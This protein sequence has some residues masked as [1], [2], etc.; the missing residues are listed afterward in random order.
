MASGGRNQPHVGNQARV[1]PPSPLNTKK[2]ASE[3]K[4]FKQM[5]ENFVIVA[6]L[7]NET[8][9]YMKALFLH[10]LG[11]DGLAIVNGLELQPNHT[12][13]DIITALDSHFIGQVNETY[14]RFVFNSR[15]QREGESFEDW[16]NC[17]RRL[18]KTCNYTPNISDSLLRDRLVHGLRNKKCVEELIQDNQLTLQSCIDKCRA[19]ESSLEQ[20]KSMNNTETE[21]HAVQYKKKKEH[22]DKHKD[23]SKKKDI[24]C[25]FC[26]RF[27]EMIKEKCPAYGEECTYCRGRNHFRDVC[28]KK[29]KDEKAKAHMVGQETDSDSDEYVFSVGHDS[30]IIK[31]EMIIDNK[32]VVCQIDSGASVNVISKKHVGKRNLKENKTSLHVYNGAA[33]QTLGTV[34]LDVHNPKTKQTYKTEF[35][36]VKQDLTTL[37]GKTTSE[38]MNLITVHYNHLSIAQVGDTANVELGYEDVFASE[39]GSLPGIAHFQIDE[40]ATPTVSASGRIPLAMKTRVKEELDRLESQGILAK[41]EEPTSWCSR[42]VVATKKSGK[43]RICIDPRP[44]NKVLKRERYPLPTLDDVIP[45][46]S[47]SKVFSKLDLSNAYWHVHLDDDSSL[48]TTFQT[49]FGRYRWR[50]LPFGTSVSSELFQKRLD[51]SLE[52]LDGVIGVS[53]D[54]IVHG[55]DMEQHDKN[56]KA[57]L[58]RCRKVGIRL[59]KEKADLRKSEITFLGHK[60]TKDGLMIDPEKL[61]AVKE[62]PKPQDVEGVRRLCGFVNY[63][64]KFL[65]KLSEVLEPIRQLTR[66]DVTWNWTP[67]CDRAFEAVQKLVT[68]APVLA[69]YDPAKQLTI[70]CDASQSGLGAVLLQDDRPIAYSSRALNKTEQNYAQ[71]E[72]E[73]LAIVFSVEKWHQYT[74]GRPV[75]IQSDHKPL[76]AIF[77]KPLSS[78][79]RRL[80]G[81]MLRI[82]GYDLHIVYKKGKE[83]TLADTL[84][85]AYIYRPS[86]QQDI[87]TINSLD[88]ILIRPERLE[89]LKAATAQDENLQTLK[90]IIMSGWPDDKTTLP[91]EIT[92]YFSFRDELSVQDGLIIKGDR[93]VIPWNM[94]AEIKKLLHSTHSGIDACLRRARECVYWPGMTSDIT[95]IV[96]GCE[97]CQKFQ[98]SN[99]PETLE[100]HDLPTRQWEKIGVDLFELEGKDYLIIVDYLSN[101][102]EIDRLRDTTATT[103]IKTMKTHIAR[104]GI[105]ST[106]VSDKGPQFTSS[107]FERFAV[108]YDFEHNTSDPY[109]HQSNGKVESA[110]KT[111]KNILK[112]NKDGDQFLALLNYRNTPSQNSNTSPAQKFFNRRTRTLLPSLPS[113]LKPK[114]TLESDIKKLRKGQVTMKHHFDKKAKDLIPLSEGDSVVMKPMRLGLKEW[115]KGTVVRGAGRSYDIEGSDGSVLRRNRVHLK[116]VPAATPTNTETQSKDLPAQDSIKTPTQTP[117]Q[118]PVPQMEPPIPSETRTTRSGRSI[119]PNRS[120]DFVY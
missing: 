13:N 19:A 83:M 100:P 30:K 75:K 109:H 69:F 92:P 10:T 47:R 17:L 97:I 54:V 48:L 95:Q 5:W 79:P 61:E 101:F 99:Q 87:E 36:V 40:T 118:T 35:M 104:Y 31:A 117:T 3:W 89:K 8:P 15:N 22:K 110:V 77:Q 23:S 60:I 114:I 21:V 2:G 12:V 76:E 39:Q 34:S 71:I 16:L 56:L 80:Q 9:A 65:P 74:F 113:L 81:M 24:K 70:Q 67:A 28:L 1:S 58:E 18:M 98:A 72:K 26:G 115:K 38:S 49:P 29:K 14:E 27:H 90:A 106:V 102:W 119:K 91:A 4:L 37:L 33:I 57:L 85:R 88:F 20:L 53:D 63:L 55:E 42:M 111:A 105:P 11:S 68:E 62:M 112:K 94:R 103:V 73:L 43:L 78:A 25:K 7:E 52:G 120:G 64:A 50:R 6:R 107:Q 84:S 86:E 41:V 32:P 93:V 116:K 51:Q 45:I 46:L 96:A 82:Q 66:D 59:N 44:L 108:D